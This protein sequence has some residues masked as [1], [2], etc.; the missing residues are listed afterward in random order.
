MNEDDIF[1]DDRNPKPLEML[2]VSDEVL[3]HR[4]NGEVSMSV[5]FVLNTS[6]LVYV[7]V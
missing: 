3:C 2:D 5:N 7:C 1:E 4:K 6:A